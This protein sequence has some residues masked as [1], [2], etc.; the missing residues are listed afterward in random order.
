MKV[1]CPYCMLNGEVDDSL[2]GK[3]IRCPQCKKSFRTTGG[4]VVSLETGK[5]KEEVGKA[6]QNNGQ[7][8][9]APETTCSTCGFSFSKEYIRSDA[10][11]VLCLVCLEA[12]TEGKG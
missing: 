5:V 9:E 4:D 11:Q 10:G 2:Y 12:K 3:K 7:R 8:A 6:P 1:T